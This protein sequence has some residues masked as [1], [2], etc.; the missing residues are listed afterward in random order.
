MGNMLKN[1][2]LNRLNHPEN[3]I[4]PVQIIH[5]NF[6]KTDAETEAYLDRAEALGIG[7]FCVNMDD[8]DG[9]LREDSAVWGA[10]ASFIDKA[11]ERDLQIWIYDERA[12]PSGAACDLV[13]KKLPDAQVKG[14]VCMKRDTDGG[15]GEWAR[16][17]RYAAAYPMENGILLKSGAIELPCENGVIRWNLPDGDWRILAFE[18]RPVNFL[19]ENK[20]PYS[21]LMRA[22]VVSG[23][24][25]I[26]HERYRRYLGDDRI[27]RITAFFTDEPGLPVH[28][29]SSY[30]YETDAVCAWTEEMDR[31]LPD[32]EKNYADLFFE[33]DGDYRKSRRMWWKT[34]ARLFGENYFGQIAEWC[35]KWGTRMT[36][37]F[38][39][40][41][42][43]A[44]QIGLNADLFGL[45]RYMQMPGVDRL[46]CDDP[47]DVTAEKTASSVA[48][49]Y[50]RTM[51]MSENSFHLE[52]NWWKTPEKAVHENRLNS[53][54]YQAQLGVTHPASYFSYPDENRADYELKAARAGLFTS[55]GT[56]KTD[57]LVLIP[58]TA[59][60]ERFAVPDHKY[61]NV[62]PCTVSP[63]QGE[64]IQK[65]EEAYG[66][67]LELL[68]DRHFDFDLIDEAGLAECTAENGR[69]STGYED[70][71]ALVAFDSGTSDAET[72]AVMER[73]LR[74]GGHIT[75]VNTDLPTESAAALAAKYPDQVKFTDAA[76]IAENLCAEP[77]LPVSGDCDGVRVKKTVTAGAELYFI[78]N[79]RDSA[80]KVTVSLSGSLTVCS[81]DMDVTDFDSAGEFEL[82]VPPKDALML[83]RWLEEEPMPEME[84]NGEFRILQLTDTQVT[85]LFQ[86]RNSIRFDQLKG[87]FFREG[88]HDNFVR[89]Y[90]SVRRLVREADPNLI[91]IT[92]DLIY[93]ETDDS[94]ALWLQFTDVM[95]SLGVPWAFVWGNHDN[96]SARGVS[97]QI[98]RLS[99]CRNCIFRRGNVT[100]N[101]NYAIRLTENGDER[102]MLVFLDT[103]GC[104][105]VGNRW[106]PEEG[107]SE[108]NPDEGLL[109]HR[110][111]IA[112]DQCAWYR[113]LM[114]DRDIP[115]YAFFH[116]P[117]HQVD[118]VYDRYNSGRKPFVCD[119]PG[120]FGEINDIGGDHACLNPDFWETAKAANCRG[121]FVGHDHR[122]NGSFMHDG[123]RITFGLKTGSH[124]S[125]KSDLLGGTLIRLKDDG[126]SVEHIY[127]Y[128]PGK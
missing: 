115:S 127:D 27:R 87:A 86:A 82:T 36:G 46:Y 31:L 106:A 8:P 47:R 88:I 13:L 78:H 75:F 3:H 80:R 73:F 58:M 72:R 16:E 109:E 45:M 124:V 2:L 84:M 52:H 116:V 24:I 9:Y 61:W 83:M 41:E 11:F 98:E 89:T 114:A 111:S 103:N 6:P 50:G 110:E 38:Y 122:N 22:D 54:Y 48:H 66:Q 94:G 39:G 35:R 107:M 56:H 30:F 21:D 15:E 18:T 53:A 63:Y 32:F 42:T 99:R 93:G 125:H 118:A 44:M 71:S 120:D 100:G 17:A 101:S 85:D 90:D 57:V 112:D 76:D 49:L 29:C 37:H 68:E 92:G 12:Y 121:M 55:Y 104:R 102:A 28:G 43:L 70:F 95:D 40:E 34:A 79:R 5:Q 117:P 105:V 69:T 119:Q 4:R 81:M 67:V 108:P 20:V 33:T 64:S 62:G 97:W 14:L 96:E 60:Y 91:I 65:L 51:V 123:I 128:A 25:E 19:T 23:F 113:D 126:F 7:G 77:V 59:A 1:H 74:A 10:L 26:T